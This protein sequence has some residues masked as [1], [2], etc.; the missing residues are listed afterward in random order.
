MI[1]PDFMYRGVLV[2]DIW[3]TG[4]MFQGSQTRRLARRSDD[5]A[6]RWQALLPCGRP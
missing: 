4:A 2:E 6:E 1:K 3:P 5:G